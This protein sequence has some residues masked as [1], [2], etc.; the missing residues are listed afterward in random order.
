MISLSFNSFSF[1]NDSQPPPAFRRG[2]RHCLGLALSLHQVWRG[3]PLPVWMGIIAM[4][5]RDWG[6]EPANSTDDASDSE[7]SEPCDDEHNDQE[8]EQEWTQEEWDQWYQ[9]NPEYSERVS[10]AEYDSGS[11]SDYD[12]ENSECD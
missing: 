4:L 6:V 7:S 2:V 10:D 9:E 8:Y 3:L 11:N 5:P 12:S 1:S